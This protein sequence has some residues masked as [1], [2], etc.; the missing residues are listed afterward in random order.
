MADPY[1]ALCFA[2]Y[3]RYCHRGIEEFLRWLGLPPEEFFRNQKEGFGL[4]V[5]GASCEFLKPVKYGEQLRL[6]VSLL[7]VREKA[8][9]F[10][11]LFRRAEGEEAVAKAQAT[12]VAIDGN[13]KSR[14][15]PERFTSALAGGEGQ[16]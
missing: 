8:L 9:T 16:R 6:L 1:G 7:K 10:G 5:V 11:F 3:F 12:M 2:S 4:P 14:P 15:L 13:W